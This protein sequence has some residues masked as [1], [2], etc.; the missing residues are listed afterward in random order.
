MNHFSSIR[1][2]FNTLSRGSKLITEMFDKRKTIYPYD[3]AIEL[4]D[5][6][7]DVVKLLL[8]KKVIIQDGTSLELEDQF[9]NF[10]ENILEVNEDINISYINENIQEVK[11]SINYYSQSNSE[12]ERFKYLKYVKAILQRIGK[13]TLRNIVD[14]NRNIDNTFKVEANYNIKL[15]KLENHKQKLEFIQNLIEQTE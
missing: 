11:D 7:E 1:D 13:S 6:N 9:L 8:S 2:L 12:N 5:D 3:H 10:F 14:L 4:L 15:T